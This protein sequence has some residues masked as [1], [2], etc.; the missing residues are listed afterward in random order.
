MSQVI[1]C[2]HAMRPGN[3]REQADVSFL[4]TNKREMA[5]FELGLQSPSGSCVTHN[6]ALWVTPVLFC[7]SPTRR[8]EQRMPIGALF[9]SG[10][11]N[12]WVAK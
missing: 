2:A 4:S 1:E 7:P 8:G 3:A 12:I 10:G 11:E 9:C 6:P 5:G